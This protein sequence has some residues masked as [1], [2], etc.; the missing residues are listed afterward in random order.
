MNFLSILIFTDAH[1]TSIINVL[2]LDLI[3]F[4]RHYDSGILA[5]QILQSNAKTVI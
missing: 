1:K 4:H 5:A 3:F 2:L